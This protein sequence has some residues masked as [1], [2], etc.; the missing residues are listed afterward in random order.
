MDAISLLKKDHDTVEELF[1]Q[2][3]KK[4]GARKGETGTRILNELEVHTQIEE[5]IFYPAVREVADEK[6]QEMV[7]EAFEE[8]RLA[9]DLIGELKRRIPAEEMYDA[10][11]K[12]LRENV[13]HHVQ[14][15]ENEM[16]PHIR[17]LMRDRLSEM[18]T[19]MQARKRELKKASGSIGGTLRGLM[20]RAYE[21]VAGP[22]TPKR[23]PKTT[24]RATSQKKAARRPRKSAAAKAKRTG[25]K[26]KKAA[27]RS[28]TS[29]KTSAQAKRPRRGQARRAVR[30]V[31][32]R[33]R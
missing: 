5:E 28:R 2:L 20:N 7:N 13:E 14:E 30:R 21:A 26:I 1:G 27:T 12:V 10:Q 15:E 31:A 32:S 4:T 22:E 33:K 19:R 18:G 25:A 23:K 24:S 17:P 3:E 11:F 9:K 8:H 29:T 6:A 16:F